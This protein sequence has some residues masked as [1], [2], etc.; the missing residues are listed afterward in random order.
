VLFATC[1]AFDETDAAS[2]T[3][4]HLHPLRLTLPPRFS[5]T[6]STSAQIYA[7]PPS[8]ASPSPPA[9][10]TPTPPGPPT[11]S[12]P[13]KPPDI[14]FRAQF[15]GLTVGAS[16]LPSLKAQYKVHS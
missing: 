15:C 8:P 6:S 7:H 11:A 3:S 4:R 10:A 16:L 9:A 13:S 1:R 2:R 14:H 5:A 12:A